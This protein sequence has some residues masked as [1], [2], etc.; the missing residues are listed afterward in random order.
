M[1]QLRTRVILLACWLIAFYNMA[2]FWRPFKISPITYLFLPVLVIVVL[3]TPR[4]MR[5]K[6]WWTLSIT[7]FIYI[8]IKLWME[9]PLAG[10][11]LPVFITET[12]AIILTALLVLWVCSAI[13]E[14]E[15]AVAQ[16]TIGRRDKITESATEG[17]VSYIGK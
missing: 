15:N 6:L 17:Q 3:I 10:I 13:L 5:V 8:V 7:T 4:L 12:L 16:I 2:H 11:A 1:K 9:L 14:F